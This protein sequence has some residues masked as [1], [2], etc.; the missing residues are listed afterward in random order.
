MTLSLA[1]RQIQ[2]RTRRALRFI[3]ASLVVYVVAGLVAA[4]ALRWLPESRR[5]NEAMFPPVFAVTSALLVAGSVCL[6]RAIGFVK[7]EKQREFRQS[8]LAA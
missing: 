1:E 7:R 4:A 5:A 3:G 6:H 8:L 2:N